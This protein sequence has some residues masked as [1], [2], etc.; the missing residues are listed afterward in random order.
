MTV[1]SAESALRR[2][3]EGNEDFSNDKNLPY[4][5]LYERRKMTVDGQSPFAVILSCSDSRVPV[6]LIFHQG[7]GDIFVIRN[8]GNIVNDNVYASV[9]YAVRYLNVN[10]VMVMGHSKCGAVSTA[11]HIAGQPHDFS[12]IIEKYVK[13]IPLPAEEVTSPTAVIINNVK[14]SVDKLEKAI[15]VYMDKDE[16]RTVKVVGS[17]YDFMTGRVTLVED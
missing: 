7:I 3:L 8:A 16:T 1:L 10:L 5:D 11:I 4:H 9:E 6:E 13:Q 15:A 17:Y 2:L 14:H 12:D